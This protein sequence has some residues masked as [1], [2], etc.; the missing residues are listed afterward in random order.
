MIEPKLQDRICEVFEY[1]K[2][3]ELENSFNDVCVLILIT[4][5]TEMIHNKKVKESIEEVLDTCYKNIDKKTIQ[6]Y[7]KECVD[8]FKT[9]E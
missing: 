7:N 9:I 4:K 3:N 6:K 8:V 5:L 2:E 1:L